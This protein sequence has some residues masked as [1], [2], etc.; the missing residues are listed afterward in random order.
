MRENGLESTLFAYFNATLNANF[1][2]GFKA[3]IE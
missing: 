1:G 3:M 2:H